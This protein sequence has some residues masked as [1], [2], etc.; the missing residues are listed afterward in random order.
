M[1]TCL[2]GKTAL[3]MVIPTQAGEG[4]DL[5]LQISKDSRYDYVEEETLAPLKGFKSSL[6]LKALGK[7]R[8]SHY[9]PQPLPMPPVCASYP[10]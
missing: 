6:C 7:S 3:Q 8:T 4:V 5:S 2:S 10:A 9:P 1:K